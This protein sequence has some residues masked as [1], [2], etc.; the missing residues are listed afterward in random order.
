MNTFKVGDRV[1]IKADGL[2]D[3]DF[4]N[5]EGTLIKKDDCTYP[6]TQVGWLVEVDTVPDGLVD[7]RYWFDSWELEPV[8]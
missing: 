6:L 1:R 5:V 2:T 4:W 7:N 3:K 8:K